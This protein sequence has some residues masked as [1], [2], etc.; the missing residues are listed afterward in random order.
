MCTYVRRRKSAGSKTITSQHRRGEEADLVQDARRRS[1]GAV[2]EHD[3]N[4][5]CRDE[6]WG[7]L[8]HM[9]HRVRAGQCRQSPPAFTLRLHPRVH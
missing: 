1:A 4:R 8:R 2:Q 5:P 9:D 7:R 3:H 6:R